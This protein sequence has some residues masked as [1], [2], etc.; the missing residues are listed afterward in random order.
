MATS[1]GI[2]PF[3]IT[4]EYNTPLLDYNIAAANGTEDRGA[5][6]PAEMGN[7]ITRK[8]QEASDFAQAAIVYAQKRVSREPL[9]TRRG[10]PL[11]KPTPGWLTAAGYFSGRGGGMGSGTH[12]K[13]TRQRPPAPGFSEMERVF[14]PYV[15]THGGPG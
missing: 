7:K 15:G 13:E 11:P 4:H 2:N 5:R 8:L 10:G 9:E 12:L 14:N 3:F 1:T 6:T